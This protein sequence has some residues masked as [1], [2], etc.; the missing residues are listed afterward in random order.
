MATARERALILSDVKFMARSYEFN[1][2][3]NG[4]YLCFAIPRNGFLTGVWLFIETLCAGTA[5][6]LTVGWLGNGETAAPAGFI[7]SDIAKCATAGYKKAISDNIS[8][9]PGK[10]F[11]SA[12]G[13][14]TVTVAGTLTAGKFFILGE[15]F[16]IT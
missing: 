12:P 11:N 15:Y 9:W 7:S 14:V 13:A 1:T 4:T 6:T 3:A 8:T 16:I 2:P 10:W 5:P